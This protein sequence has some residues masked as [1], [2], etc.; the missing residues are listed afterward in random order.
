VIV[1]QPFALLALRRLIPNFDVSFTKSGG[2]I[3]PWS[4]NSVWSGIPIKPPQSG[5]RGGR[6]LP[7]HPN[8]GGEEQPNTIWM[9]RANLEV[10]LRKQFLDRNSNIEVVHGVVT[11]LHEGTKGTIDKVI[12]TAKDERGS[13]ELDA[14]LVVGKCND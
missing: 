14:E 9:T 1:Y 7:H 3:K 5:Y 12:Y 10:Y 4:Y 2:R 11:G 6:H 13:S 8:L